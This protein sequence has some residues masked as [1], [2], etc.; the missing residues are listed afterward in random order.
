ML[1]RF[2]SRR[3][4]VFFLYD[5]I[6]SFLLFLLANQIR[7]SIGYLPTWL[8][9]ELDVLGI[10]VGG[11]SGAAD[12][13]FR[14]FFLLVLTFPLFLINAG[15]Y[16]ARKSFALQAE[17]RNIFVGLSVAFL[18]LSGL[19]FFT[20]R[21]TSRVMV[22]IFYVMDLLFLIIGRIGLTAY[23]QLFRKTNFLKM[24][25]VLVIGAGEVGRRIVEQL[26]DYAQY[27]HIQLV[28]YL[29]DNRNKLGQTISGLPVLGTLDDVHKVMS[30]SNVEDVVIALPLRAHER[31]IRVCQELDQ[32][33]VRTHI[34][35]DLFVLSFQDSTLDGFGGIPVITLGQRKF[36]GSRRAAKRIF[37]LIFGSLGLFVI[38]PILL[39]F[40]LL[41]KLESPGPA[42]YKTK[43]IGENGKPF[44]MYKFRSMV[45]NASSSGHE[46]YVKRLISENLSPDDVADITGQ[47]SLKL[48]DD[49]RVT[50]IGKF[51]RKTSIDELPQLFNVLR[52]EMSLVGPRPPLPYEYEVYQDWH[53]ER[54]RIIPGMTGIWQVRAHN[55]VSFDEMVRMDVEYIKNQSIWLDL[56]I[57]IQT[58]IALLTDQG[59]G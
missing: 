2:S 37:D 41:I 28:G 25:K 15:V 35:P 44:T 33:S 56:L 31:L 45:N 46:E 11:V 5:F 51:I 6:G 22:L 1:R 20:Y 8:S 16:D 29:D 13:T 38:S 55:K 54:L 10:V 18:T 23:N 7:T 50:R 19:L 53:K 12:L 34:I 14:P 26:Q 17:I 47:K 36:N 52:G 42:I 21:E 57:I 58:P 9:S 27:E 4:I 49:N 30:E 48:K 32:F 59:S 39:V 3:V 40:A 43:R 24:R